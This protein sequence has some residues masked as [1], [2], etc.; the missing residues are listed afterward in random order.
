MGRKLVNPVSIAPGSFPGCVSVASCRDGIK[1][2]GVLAGL[3][4]GMILAASAIPFVAGT[5]FSDLSFF[6]S[7]GITYKDHGQVLDGIQILKNHG[8]NCVRL[9][10]WTG[11]DAFVRTNN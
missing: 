7:R 11:S 1:R 8:I 2:A 6:E 3:W 9:R 4:L 5:D 10:L